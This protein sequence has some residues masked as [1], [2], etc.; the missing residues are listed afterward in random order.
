M[1]E[2]LTVV[3]T[4]I[5]GVLGL[6]VW[7]TSFIHAAIQADGAWR[8]VGRRRSRW[9]VLLLLFGWIAGILYLLLVRPGLRAA[10]L[11]TR[12][13]RQGEGH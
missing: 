5:L 10:V 7:V 12:P 9:V 6:A 8:A 1:S 4:S 11:A 2:T 13:D 3:G